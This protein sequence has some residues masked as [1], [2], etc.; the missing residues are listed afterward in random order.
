MTRIRK[1]PI[2]RGR[3]MFAE[4]AMMVL[5]GL[6]I[7]CSSSPKAMEARYLRR[8]EALMAKK[9][10]SRALLEFKNASGVM[11]KD[12]EPKYQTG[13][14]YLAL[15]DLADRKSTRLNSSHRCI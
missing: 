3:R 15:G 12:A 4:G 1:T 14:A 5:F 2:S 6:S 13:L 7:L 9:D 10:Y 11:P 8:G